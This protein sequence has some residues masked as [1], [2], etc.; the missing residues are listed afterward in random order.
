MPEYRAQYSVPSSDGRRHYTISYTDQNEWQCSCLGWTRHVPRSDCRHITIV[1]QADAQ[2]RWQMLTMGEENHIPEFGGLHRAPTTAQIAREIAERQANARNITERLASEARAARAAEVMAAEERAAATAQRIANAM[3]AERR[4]IEALDPTLTSG[5][6]ALF[7]CTCGWIGFNPAA[8]EHQSRDHLRE[9]D[10]ARTIP[11][12]REWI[13]QA[14]TGGRGVA[15]AGANATTVSPGEITAAVT[16]QPRAR[17]RANE[18]PCG[19]EMAAQSFISLKAA[20]CAVCQ[21]AY[22]VV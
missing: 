4:R 17:R 21:V 20:R 2:S 13:R 15:A 8:A 1:R 9:W 18:Q 11:L 6:N 14:L 16:P 12:A 22:T 5:A 7:R 10:S 3:I 19:H